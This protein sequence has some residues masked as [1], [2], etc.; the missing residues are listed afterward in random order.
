LPGGDGCLLD[1][2]WNDPRKGDLFVI[3]SAVVRKPG[4]AKD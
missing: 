3:I 1:T 2:E 4:E